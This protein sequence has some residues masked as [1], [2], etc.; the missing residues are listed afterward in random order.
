MFDKEKNWY[1]RSLEN[2]A[3]SVGRAKLTRSDSVKKAFIESFD[4]KISSTQG[5]KIISMLDKSSGSED[6][7]TSLKEELSDIFKEVTEE[8]ISKMASYL[9]S[10]KN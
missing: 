6:K 2:I 4:L 3:D 8:D 9:Y 1:L 7:M 5:K 10:F